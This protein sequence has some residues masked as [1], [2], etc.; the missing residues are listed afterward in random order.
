V[1]LVVERLLQRAG[2]RADSVATVGEALKALEAAPDAFDLV[3]SDFNMPGSSGLDL[4]R[5]VARLHPGLPVVIATGYVSDELRRS[6]RDVG[7]HHILQKQNLFEEL[8]PLAQRILAE[9]APAASA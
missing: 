4:A 3:V 6:A 8:V 9:C 1:R 2:L 5:D 7:V